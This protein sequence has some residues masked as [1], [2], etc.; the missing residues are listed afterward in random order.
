MSRKRGRSPS[1]SPGYHR[2]PQRT[3][4]SRLSPPLSPL[5]PP[6]SEIEVCLA[7]FNTKEG[8]NFTSYA[9]AFEQLDL[10]PDVIPSADTAPHR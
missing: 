2:T 7:A 5:P 1:S 3:S 6:G 10:T 4:T 9:S 8:I